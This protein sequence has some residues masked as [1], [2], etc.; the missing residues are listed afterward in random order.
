MTERMIKPGDV[1]GPAPGGDD[2][3]ARGGGEPGGGDVHTLAG[4][5]P[6]CDDVHARGGVGGH[7]VA[8]HPE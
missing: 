2:V 8:P 1:K 7:F 5:E 4:G 6:G 3:H